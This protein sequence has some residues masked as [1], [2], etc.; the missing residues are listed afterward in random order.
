VDD[1]LGQLGKGR[2]EAIPDPPGKELARRILE[3][4]NLVQVVVIQTIE[5]GSHRTR[6]VGEVANPTGLLPDWPFDLDPHA[7]RVSVETSA[8]VIRRHV[9]ETVRGLEPELLEDLHHR[10]PADSLIAAA[11]RGW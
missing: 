11:P 4:G 2:R 7:E 5:D 8:F 10:T 1:D 3:S 9:R 6:H